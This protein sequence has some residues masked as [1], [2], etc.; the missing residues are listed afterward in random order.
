MPHKDIHPGIPT[1]SNPNPVILRTFSVAIVDE[2]RK[3]T[4]PKEHLKNK[5]KKHKVG[6][7]RKTIMGK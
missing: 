6:E 1:L 3:Q 7:K 5:E 2:R 4:E